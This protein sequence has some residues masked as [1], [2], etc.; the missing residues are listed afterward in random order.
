[1]EDGHKKIIAGVLGIIAIALVI[2]VLFFS[3]DARYDIN[4]PDPVE[5][6]AAVEDYRNDRTGGSREVLIRVAESDNDERVKLASI[7]AMRHNRDEDTEKALRRMA[8]EE[9]SPAVRGEAWVVLAEYKNVATSE[10]TGVLQSES[11]PIVRIGAAQGLA[12]R[13]DRKSAP[14]MFRALGDPDEKVRAWA[15]TAIRQITK[16]G[17]LYDAGKTPGEQVQV[18]QQIGNYLRRNGFM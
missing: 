2:N 1:M 13:A 11:N 12:N 15:I 10:L 3:N 18:I 7:S 16:V 5:R 4:S 6:L 8:R 9:K 14:N 17:F